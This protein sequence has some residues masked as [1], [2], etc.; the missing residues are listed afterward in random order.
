MS[1]KSQSIASRAT[2]TLPEATKQAPA[3]R[4][5]ALRLCTNFRAGNTLPSCATRG[6][7]EVAAILETE[8]GKRDMPLKFEKV[9]CLGKC[10]IGPTMRLVPAG[11]FIMGAQTEEDVNRILDLLEKDDAETAAKEYPLTESG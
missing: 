7:Q 6:A 10:H 5:R 11:P 3:S 1:E 8:W 9:H 4:F 2:E